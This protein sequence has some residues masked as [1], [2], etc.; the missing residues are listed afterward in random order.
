MEFSPYTMKSDTKV[1]FIAYNKYIVHPVIN[2]SVGFIVT[3]K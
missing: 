1:R 2:T 3:Q